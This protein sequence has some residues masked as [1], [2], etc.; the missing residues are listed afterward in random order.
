[1]TDDAYIA[2]YQ[3]LAAQY[4]NNQSSMADYLSAVQKLKDQFLKGRSGAQLPL[5]P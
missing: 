3:K 2:A 5:V 1:M 4:H